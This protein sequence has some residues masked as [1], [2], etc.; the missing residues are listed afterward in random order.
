[1]RRVKLSIRNC[2]NAERKKNSLWAQQNKKKKQKLNKLK[3]N[4]CGQLPCIIHSF[5][6]QFIG[7]F[8]KKRNMDYGCELWVRYMPQHR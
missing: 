7:E 3:Q 5:V 4:I 2:G 8:I 1:M 6:T